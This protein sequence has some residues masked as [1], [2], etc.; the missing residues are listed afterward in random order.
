MTYPY[1][2][3][4][5]A[6][7]PH[8]AR[9]VVLLVALVVLLVMTL[10]SLALVR[11]TTTGSSIAGSLALKQTATTGADLGLEWGL[12][13]LDQLSQNGAALESSNASAG[14]FALFTP[15]T[16][17]KDLPWDAAGRQATAD[18]GL[19]NEVRYMIH[20]LCS[21]TGAWNAEGQSCVM[22]QGTGCPGSSDSPGSVV[23]CN[24]RPMY[25]ISARAVGPRATV[26]YVQMTVY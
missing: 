26:S 21:A 14:Y 1:R 20:R 7:R 19:G 2:Q 4:V 8:G 18:D 10:T 9:G 11:T 13:Q 12:A 3:R 15:T 16:A 23:P 25:R 6:T 17:A 22:P 24:D 5:P